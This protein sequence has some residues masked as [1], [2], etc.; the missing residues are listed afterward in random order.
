MIDY[1]LSKIEKVAVHNVG[2]KNNEEELYI[3][4]SLLDI[5][6]EKIRDLLFKFFLGSFVNPEYYAF[7]S[8]NEDFRI[9]PIYKYAVEIFNNNNSLQKNAVEIATLL[10]ELSTHPQI[11]S[12]DLF[13]AY[14]SEICVEDEITQAIGIFKSENKQSFLKLNRAN[15]SYEI[16]SDDGINVEKLDKGCLI[17]NTDKDAGYK[18]CMIDKSGKGSE[19][20]FWMDSFLQLKPYTDVYYYTKEQMN[21]TKD[22]ITK[23]LTEEFDVNRAEQID[24]LN[25]SADYF[26]SHGTFEKDEYEKEVFRNPKMIRS[27]RE[28]DADYRNAHDIQMDDTFDISP[29]AVKR[30]IKIFKGVLKLD[31][32]F[33]IYIHGDKE[34]IVPGM[35]PD[36]RK[37]YKVYFENES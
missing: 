25:R 34:L 12:G 1:T 16:N 20:K 14:F 29:S 8:E 26:K 13:V 18:I 7:T 33:H 23:Q 2:N 28:Y 19:A 35:E 22:Y 24:L 37:F 27:F 31:K 32:N 11:K 21:I 6:D 5:S 9:N 30:Q 10:Y 36:G 4:K 15:G 3:S 17:F